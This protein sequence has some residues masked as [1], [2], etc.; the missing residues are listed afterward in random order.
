MCDWQRHQ[1]AS[2]TVAATQTI[3]LMTVTVFAL[4]TCLFAPLLAQLPA[5]YF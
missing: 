2:G 4:I 1:S 5:T 3:A